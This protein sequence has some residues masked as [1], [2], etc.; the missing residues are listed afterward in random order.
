MTAII[1]DYYPATAWTTTASHLQLIHACGC[2]CRAPEWTIGAT[3]GRSKAPTPSGQ[4]VE[5]KP[6]VKA[7]GN[8]VS[9]H[10]PAKVGGIDEV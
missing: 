8:P 9:H 5:S 10:A 7:P 6:D 1:G 2:V 4:A 3:T